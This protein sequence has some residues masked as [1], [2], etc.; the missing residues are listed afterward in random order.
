MLGIYPVHGNDIGSLISREEI[1]RMKE[2]GIGAETGTVANAVVNT[3][4]DIVASSEISIKSGDG[5][6]AVNPAAEQRTLPELIGA[7]VAR[8]PEGN[9]T[10]EALNAA[11]AAFAPGPERADRVVVK[12]IPFSSARKWQ[13]VVFADGSSL[14]LGAAELMLSRN[15]LQLLLPEINRLAA[16][17]MRILTLAYLPEPIDDPSQL[18]DDPQ[19]IAL[20]A[21]G[22][23]IRSDAPETFAYFREQQVELKVIS[24]DNPVT[25]AAV[26]RRAGLTAA[27]TELSYIDMS[28][29][30][31]EPAGEEPGSA[32]GGSGTHLIAAPPTEKDPNFVPSAMF[33][34]SFLEIFPTPDAAPTAKSALPPPPPPKT[35]PKLPFWPPLTS[36]RS[37]AGDPTTAEVST[38]TAEDEAAAIRRTYDEIVAENTSSDGFR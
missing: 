5:T 22:D 14:L 8:Q 23:Q 31:E 3:E 28:T 1:E 11:F 25:V 12:Q 13:A 9:A 37:R 16:E 24:G 29:V 27:D 26:A 7:L 6:S 20:I 33:D 2:S 35:M 38:A 10:Q 18:P 34:F 15:A 17:G 4:A 32:L 30:P 36:R 19:A 21:I